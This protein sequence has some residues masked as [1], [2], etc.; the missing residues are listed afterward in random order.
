MNP[1]PYLNSVRWFTVRNTTKEVIPGYAVMKL[2]IDRKATENVYIWEQAGN[3]QIAL[4]KK[5]DDDSQANQDWTL[6]CF[7]S[8]FHI[9]PGKWGNATIDFPCRVLH[10]K[11]DRTFTGDVAGLQSGKWW[12]SNAF[13]AY[14]SLGHAPGS[15]FATVGD[16]IWVLPRENQYPVVAAGSLDSVS[17]YT[18]NSD[19]AAEV[20]SW[21][22]TAAAANPAEFEF[23]VLPPMN[24]VEFGSTSV[25]GLT[26]TAV[27]PLKII[28]SG[29]Y[30]LHFDA[31]VWLNNTA[32]AFIAQGKSI[33]LQWYRN[34]E[35][36][37]ADYATYRTQADWQITL[38][39]AVHGETIENEFIDSRE[40]V[41]TTQWA[42]LE[43]DD[44]L[45]LR[46]SIG[47]AGTGDRRV[48]LANGHVWIERRSGLPHLSEGTHAHQ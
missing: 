35:S 9:E 23:G 31:V 41:A 17:L 20:L 46:I 37:G 3:R 19:E 1:L 11:L 7:N 29:D 4:V 30:L 21:D 43:A 10:E 44:L 38:T 33:T 25:T 8:P 12:L 2:G 36:M 47:P 34:G 39:G 26:G 32:N 28:R 14:R 42:R 40:N 16:C 18:I 24:G 13:D 15:P 45:S 6:H 22:F 48:S 5:P 27:Y